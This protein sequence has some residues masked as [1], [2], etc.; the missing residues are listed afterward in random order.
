MSLQ[1]KERFFFPPFK[2][3]QKISSSYFLQEDRKNWSK[4]HISVVPAQPV[5]TT[6]PGVLISKETTI[7]HISL[8]GLEG[9]W[10]PSKEREIDPTKH[11]NISWWPKIW[12]EIVQFSSFPSQPSPTFRFLWAQGKDPQKEREQDRT[13]SFLVELLFVSLFLFS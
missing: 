4:S 9:C 11:Q 7:G 8:L 3:I 1:D 10:W 13:Q 2:N 5:F 12:E 6:Q